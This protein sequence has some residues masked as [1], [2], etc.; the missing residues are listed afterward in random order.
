MF[1]LNENYEVDRRFLKCDFI[2]YSPAETSTINTPNSQIY[3][4][5]P[6]EDSVISLLNSY[7]DLNFEVI[8]RADNSRYANGN[9]IR[10]VNL[11]PFALFSNSKLTTSSGKQLEDISHAY[12]VSLMYKLIT[13]SKNSD[14]FSIGFDRSRARR[15]DVLTDNKRV[16]G[17]YHVRIMPND[18]FGFAE[19]QEKATYGLGYKLTLTR[20]KDEAVIDKAAGIAE[21][22]IKLDH[23]H[24]YVPH[25]IPSMQQEAIMSEQI[26]NKTPTELRYVERP[27]FMKEVNNQNV[28][29]FELGSQENMNVPIWINIGFQ[30]QI[31]QDSQN[32]NND[33]FYRLPVVSAQCVIGTEKYP[34][35]G[36]LSNYDDDD[37]S[38]GYHLIKQAFKA[39][40]K[41]DILQPYISEEDF[42]SSN[43]GVNDVGY[44]LYVFDIR[45]QK[46]YTASQPIKVEFE[47]DGV[48]PNNI[49]GYALV[50]TNKLVSISLDGQRHFDLIY[51]MFN[52][53]ITSLVSFNVNSVFFNNDSLY[54]SGKLSIR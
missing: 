7:L 41:G 28:W 32:L 13:S 18:V 44:N 1:K 5:I 3:I 11:G 26:L 10:L 34:D 49:N 6:R 19:H 25:Y 2:R 24:W 12:L 15:Q 53:F 23:I 40:T 54:L 31:K 30:Q 9:D 46:N 35:A 43:A 22:R 33:T 52:F 37:Y 8:K 51:V 38:Q 42:R 36:I 4:N 47:F 17:K 48:V 20:N 29:N 16:K 45:Y 14:D 21:A 50:L 27:V 39:L